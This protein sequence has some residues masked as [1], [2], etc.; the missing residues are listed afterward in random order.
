MAIGSDDFPPDFVRTRQNFITFLVRQR[1]YAPIHNTDEPSS[2]H[3]ITAASQKP[4]SREIIIPFYPPHSFPTSTIDDN[5]TQCFTTYRH[6][7]SSS[8]YCYNNIDDVITWRKRED[9]S[10]HGVSNRSHPLMAFK[11]TSGRSTHT[12][13]DV[14]TQDRYRTS[15]CLIDPVSMT[16]TVCSNLTAFLLTT[17]SPHASKS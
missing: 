13:L 3:T 14:K 15:F 2:H 1:P 7:Y 8:L 9:W 6:P 16:L 12:S 17:N 11:F 5:M 10:A 4:M